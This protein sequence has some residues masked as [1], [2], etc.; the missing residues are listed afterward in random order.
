MKD[1]LF[2]V[3][4]LLSD[5]FPTIVFAILM[6]LHV[7]VRVATAAALLIGL[8]QVVV[9]KALKR[10]VELLQWASLGLVVVFGT[11]GILTN[12]PRFL[13]IKPTIIYVAIGVVMLKR[14][15]MIRYLPADAVEHVADLQIGWGYAWSALMFA[16]AI[17]NGLIAWSFPAVWPA[18]IAV[19]PLASK[20]LMFAVHFGSVR[21]IGYLRYR[22]G[23]RALEAKAMEP[24]AAAAA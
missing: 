3:R 6:A 10:P 2:A 8:G 11:L 19:V 15:W 16:T 23:Q 24:A 18:F 7:D 4:P 5:F 21:Y 17:A 1:L 13:M 9:Q 20:A 14:G 22:A 12:D